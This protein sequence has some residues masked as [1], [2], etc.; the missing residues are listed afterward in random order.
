MAKIEIFIYLFIYLFIYFYFIFF[1]DRILLFGP[2][3][4]LTYFVALLSLKIAT[5][6][7]AWSSL[8]WDTG[9]FT[10]PRFR[11]QIFF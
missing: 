1:W 3:W 5:V 6:F 8:F 4:L 7:L 11:N 10:T 2:D 9:L